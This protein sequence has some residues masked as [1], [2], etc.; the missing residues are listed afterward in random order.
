MQRK[1]L[2]MIPEGFSDEI[3]RFIGDSRIYDSSCSKEARVYFIEKDRGYFLKTSALGTLSREAELTAYFHKRGLGAEVVNY[4]VYEGADWLLTARVPGEDLTHKDYIAEPK[5][6]SEFLGSKL[7]ELHELDFSD[8]PVQN[9]MKEYLALAEE[10][11]R[12]GNY[13]KSAFPDSFGYASAEEAHA[14]LEKEKGALK[15]NVL[16]HGD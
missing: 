7:R 11:Y 8:C 16:L 15:N 9:R 13:D 14:V 2:S 1:L 5:R 12:T 10:N 3:R 6:L 4:S